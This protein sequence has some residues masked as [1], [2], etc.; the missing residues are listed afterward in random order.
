MNLPNYVLAGY[1]GRD[2]WMNFYISKK[3][4]KCLIF[5]TMWQIGMSTT[6]IVQ[7]VEVETF[8]FLIKTDESVIQSRLNLV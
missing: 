5:Q 2:L 4:S 8:G 3:D 6:Q 7:D 1:F